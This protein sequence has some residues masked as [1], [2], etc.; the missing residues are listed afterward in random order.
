MEFSSRVSGLEAERAFEVMARARALEASGLD[1]IHLG[2]GEPDFETPD[3]I[4]Q[5]GMRAI[6][7]G[8]TRY[9]PAVGMAELRE[10]IAEDAGRR[11]GISIRP[12][13]VV[14]SPGAK[15]PII[16]AALALIEPG[17]GDEVILPDPGYPA[18]RA[19]GAVAGCIPAPAPLLEEH[20]F[21]FDFDQF[22]RLV[23]PR[24]RLIILNTPGNPT[25]GVIPA[26][27]L[28]R[29]AGLARRYDCWVI[30]DEIYSRI[31]FD[32][33]QVPSIAALPGMAERTIVV[34]GFSKTYSMTGW[35]LGYG[36]MPE[37]LADRI[38]IL[39]NHSVG[40]NAHFTQA[41]GI[42]ALLGT[43]ESVD[44]MRAEYER[45][46]D[47]LTAGLN[48]IPGVRCSIPQGSFYAFPNVSAFGRP[49]AELANLLLEEAG[50]A[51]VPGTAF[52]DYGEG[53][54]RVAFTTSLEK[55]EQGI[56]RMGRFFRTVL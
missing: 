47:C 36:I 28:E 15:P 54:L 41:A 2:I 31:A 14:V 34:D 24:T 6:G 23:N 12:S 42:E 10:V 39:L 37:A 19:A 38:Q 5:A 32:G 33:L 4:R 56:E 52:G 25:G 48:A 46:R 1:V 43:Q 35:R 3:N 21:S 30:S 53:Y 29:I 16:L 26:A 11:R 18:D 45:R 17:R 50:V 7:D 27:D 8:Q 44:E 13:Q 9:T 40:C 22:E 20:G 49:S 55:I 51:L